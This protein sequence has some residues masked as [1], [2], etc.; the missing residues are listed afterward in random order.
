MKVATG[1]GGKKVVCITNDPPEN[2]C[3]P[4]ADYLFRSVAKEY[5]NRATGVIMTGMG[6][7]GT[8]GLKL[9]DTLILNQLD[10]SITTQSNEKFEYI[11]KFKL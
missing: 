7:D 3:K 1:V 6:Q 4:A 9:V 2:N 11:I 8:L 10:G 5:R